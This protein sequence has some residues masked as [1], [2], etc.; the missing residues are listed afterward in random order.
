MS[1]NRVTNLQVSRLC[2]VLIVLVSANACGHSLAAPPVPSEDEAIQVVRAYGTGHASSVLP[3]P[4]QI[5]EETTE[6]YQAKIKEL[7]L[8]SNFAELE[9]IAQQNRTD[10]G[11]LRGGSWKSWAFYGQLGD[12]PSAGKQTDEDYQNHLTRLNEWTAAYPNSAAARIALARFYTNYADFA[13]GGGY[14]N[15][16]SDAQWSLYGERTA[17]AERQ[18]FE[19]A[20]LKD[21]DAPW[22]QAMQEVAFNQGWAKENAQELLA[23]ALAFEPS[24]YHFYREYADYLKPQWYGEP[25]EIARY[26]EQASLQLKD[27]EASILYFR[28]TSTLAC[29]C[30]PQIADLPGLDWAKY[31]SGYSYVTKLYGVDNVNANRLAWVAYKMGDKVT[32]QQA[33]A[34][35]DH[36][37]MGVWWGPHTFAN[38]RDWASAP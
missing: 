10:R 8:E 32:A 38:A 2:V 13:R 18:L 16:V 19:A 21:R 26:A 3:A 33:F 35:V 31:K 34:S 12:P 24:Y 15:T 36:M 25:G 6:S 14:A 4:V 7:V 23:Q 5:S 28:F 20:R 1:R 27:P 22:Y 11:L 9:K 37:E 17:L 30:E 29:N